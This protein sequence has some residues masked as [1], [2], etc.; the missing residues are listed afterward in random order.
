MIIV[1]WRTTTV[2][3]NLLPQPR[4]MFQKM[5]LMLLAL[6]L[7]KMLQCDDANLPD[8]FLSSEK[9]SF[10][11]ERATHDNRV[12]DTRFRRWSQLLTGHLKI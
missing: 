12:V 7:S 6:L 5:L 1:C 8:L 11:A 10:S 3:N 2:D 4:Y 9:T